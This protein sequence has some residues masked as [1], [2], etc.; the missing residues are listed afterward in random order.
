MKSELLI[1]RAQEHDL[2]A[3]NALYNH[4]IENTTI[5]FDLDPWSMDQ[6]RDWFAQFGADPRHILLV[7]ERAGAIKG[8]AGTLEFRKK[9]AY[10]TSVE[11]T[12]YVA[13]GAEGQG[14]GTRLYE[15]LLPLAA[16]AGAHRALAGITLPNDNSL[17]MHEKF[18]F[19]PVGIFSE[20]GY[21]F[22]RYWDVGWYER[23]L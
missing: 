8:Y 14:V 4:Y 16:A 21:K 9:K 10:Q 12:I 13:P 18:G 7:A 15:E 17:K 11:T 20:V 1:R 2:A 6:R 5:T 22:G 3:I 19:Q 23:A